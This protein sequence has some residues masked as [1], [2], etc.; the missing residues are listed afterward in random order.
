MKQRM[1]LYGLTLV[2]GCFVLASCVNDDEGPCLPDSNG[3]TQVVFSL[4]LPDKAQTRSLWGE[5][6]PDSGEWINDWEIGEDKDNDIDL[7][8]I[9]IVIFDNAGGYIGTLGDELNYIPRNTGEEPYETTEYEC[10]GTV[11]DNIAEALIKA[12]VKNFKFV[13][14]ANCT[15]PES[16]ITW[17]GLKTAVV[18]DSETDKIPM[19]GVV[20]VENLTLTKGERTDLGPIVLLRALSKVTVALAPKTGQESKMDGFEFISSVKVTN[21]NTKGYVVP[22]LPAYESVTNTMALDIVGCIHVNT[23]DA[24]K[25][26]EIK[27]TTET[28]SLTFWLFEFVNKGKEDANQAQL[29]VTLGKTVK[30]AETGEETVTTKEF[31][32]APIKF[33]AYKDG[34]PTATAYDIVRNHYY[35]FNIT[36]VVGG[37]YVVPT[38]ADWINAPVIEYD[39]NMSTNIRLFDSWLYRYDKDNQYGWDDP[40]KPEDVYNHW[41]G[42]HMVVSSGRQNLTTVAEP[43]AGRPLHSPQIQLMT[44]GAVDP[45]DSDSGTFELF[46][47]NTDF[48]IV[49]AVKDGDGKVTEYTTSNNDGILTIPAGEKVYTYFYIV[50]KEGSTPSNS[51][52]KVFLYYNDPVTGKQEVPYNRSALP[53]YSDDSSEIWAYFVTPDKYNDEQGYMK[54]YYQDADNPLVPVPTVNP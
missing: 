6:D 14:F 46:V 49:Q 48:E 18:F 25:G 11:P 37:L 12:Q 35:K 36:E 41:Q 26:L 53:G 43:I 54:M 7:G 8:T 42:S 1:I 4:V 19:W 29:I 32:F 2:L 50:P 16:N 27:G 40:E 51:V 20:S 30:D 24:A 13:V 17:D 5:K 10:I 23:T 34:A 45:D 39:I 38:V 9:R 44:T 15:V 21:Y 52:A 33:C 47:D 31:D 28:T 3:K 22:T